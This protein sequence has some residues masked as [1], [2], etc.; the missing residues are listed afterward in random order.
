MTLLMD[1]T[2]VYLSKN[3][4]KYLGLSCNELMG[5]SIFQF[6]HPSDHN[7]IKELLEL[8]D[9]FLTLSMI[10][11]TMGSSLNACGEQEAFNK[12]VPCEFLLRMMC[13]L[14]T[15]RMT[16]NRMTNDG[17]TSYKVIIR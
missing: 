6:S 8:K 17:C 5:C 15:N 11:S 14:T 13:K 12:R 10:R 2:M 4:E 9:K 16:T 3:V 1:G 7:G